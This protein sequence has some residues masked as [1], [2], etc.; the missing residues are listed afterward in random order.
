MAAEQTTVH[1]LGILPQPR[2]AVIGEERS[3][4]GASGAFH[5]RIWWEHTRV[6]E[7]LELQVHEITSFQGAV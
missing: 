7:C 4:T 3:G 5:H 6:A 2:H 1:M